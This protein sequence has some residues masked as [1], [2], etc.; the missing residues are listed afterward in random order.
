[1]KGEYKNES[2]KLDETFKKKDLRKKRRRK[3]G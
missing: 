3:K 1:M 2:I